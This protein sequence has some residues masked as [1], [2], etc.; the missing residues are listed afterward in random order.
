[1]TNKKL[2]K[3]ISF[4]VAFALLLSGISGVAFP[5]VKADTSRDIYNAAKTYIDLNQNEVTLEGL[6]TAVKVVNSE[7]TLSASDFYIK[8]AVPGVK[9]VM[10]DGSENEYPLNI[11]GSDGAVAAIFEYDGNRYPFVYAFE[12]EVETIEIN[13]V[14]VVGKSSGFSYGGSANGGKNVV[15]YT[16]TAD[17]IVFPEGYQGTMAV[18]AVNNVKVVIYNNGV[19]FFGN[20]FKGSPSL[21]AVQINNG[22]TAFKLASKTNVWSTET[23]ASGMFSECPELKYFKLPNT[24]ANEGTHYW[25]NM[26]P[27][28]FLKDCPKLEN[29]V[30]AKTATGCP[31]SSYGYQ[32]F[33][34]T[35][36]RD[37]VL[38]TSPAAISIKE[39]AF[40]GTTVAKGTRNIHEYTDEMTFVR[41]VALAAAAVNTL[42]IN[43]NEA[44]IINAAKSAITGSADSESFKNGL[45]FSFKEDAS[46]TKITKI[47]EISNGTD[48]F[49]VSI[50]A[51]LVLSDLDAA[52]DI[53]KN[54]VA[55]KGNE[56]T[57]QELL[58]VVKGI[59]PE[60]TLDAENDFYIKHAIP[61]VKD[62]MADGSE[63]K[64][65]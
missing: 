35:A 37:V 20:A 55:E 43:E 51:S 44:T 24:I 39:D 33:Y 5:I 53:A 50:S 21:K 10:A 42:D 3:A 14:A 25:F 48:K 9:D 4:L 63:N 7:V 27:N 45:N 41:A 29:V 58:D 34:G 13:E 64:Y 65:L 49:E 17:K 52:F 57:A 32:V 18:A 12:H 16:G 62:V 40:G 19:P 60:V 8:H 1:M 54:F 28:G 59:V 23:K 6:L 56:I 15:G 47:V 61:G 26:F 2:Q 36:I 46:E 38:P 30:M 11:E 22:D 31:F